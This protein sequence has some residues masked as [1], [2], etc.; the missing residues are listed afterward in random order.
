MQVLT[1]E[2]QRRF[3]ELAVFANNAAI[4]EEAILTLWSHT[5][6]LD[7]LEAADFL[8]EFSGRSLVQLD[9]STDESGTVKVSVSVHDLLHDF[10]T[11]F[12]AQIFGD[13]AALHRELLDAYQKRCLD[14][15]HTSPNDG[16]FLEHLCE[17]LLKA[18]QFED[19]IQV[20]TDL[21]FLI[22]IGRT[23]DLS[24]ITGGHLRW[25]LE[26]YVKQISA[27]FP[28]AQKKVQHL[29]TNLPELCAAVELQFVR[30]QSSKD[31]K[32]HEDELPDLKK[33]LD[34]TVCKQ[35]KWQGIFH[36]HIDLGAIDFYD[37]YWS[38]CPNCLWAWHTEE[39]SN[40]YGGDSPVRRFDP[41]TNT[42]S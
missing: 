33:G 30:D 34:G 40:S 3:A 37:N 13:L 26:P 25:F 16:Y 39:Y 1:S 24:L 6:G 27:R 4:P 18:E 42:Y 35:C 22:K 2:E 10:A 19:L 28:L 8:V 12:A 17:H 23:F 5:G 11:R 32:T 21:R 14:G 20:L 38:L 7:E 15:W 31:G 29:K 36:G 41:A 9:R